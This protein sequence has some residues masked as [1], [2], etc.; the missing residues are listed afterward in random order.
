[1]LINF[2]K[3]IFQ[4]LV[5]SSKVWD[6]DGDGIIDNGGYADQT[7]DA[8]VMKGAR[9]SYANFNCLLLF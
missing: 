9:Y 6:V 4:V 8:W 5:E 7:F 1:M 2:H 3:N